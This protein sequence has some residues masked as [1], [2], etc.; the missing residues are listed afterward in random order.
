MDASLKGASPKYDHD[1]G[2]DDGH[3]GD[4]DDHEDD[5]GLNDDGDVNDVDDHK[6]NRK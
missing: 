6:Q 5:D 4:V 1:H 3:C 2:D